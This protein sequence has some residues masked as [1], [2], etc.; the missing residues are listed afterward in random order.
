MSDPNQITPVV[1]ISGF[2][3]SGKTTLLTKWIEYYK[4]MNQQVAVIMNE[5]GDV[6]L[7]GLMINESI[8]M[9][10]MLSGCICC[11]IRGDL[12]TT[13]MNLVEQE[14]PNVILIESTGAANPLELIDGV[15]E[16]SLY[17]RIHLQ[18][19]V[20]IVDGPHLLELAEKGIGKTYK[21]MKEQ[22][23]CADVVLLNKLDR[24][25][26]TELSDLQKVVRDINTTAT[27]IETIQ[28]DVD[29]TLL[30][31][32]RLNVKRQLAHKVDHNHYPS[33]ASHTHHSH[34]HVMVYT[35]YFDGPVDSVRF[36]QFISELPHSVYRAKGVLRF[37]DTPQESRFL[38]QYAYRE[39]DYLRITPKKDTPDVLV[40]IGEH[41]PKVEIKSLLDNL[42]N[43]MECQSPDC[44]DFG[45]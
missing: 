16:A 15:T 8:P 24:V 36:E 26:S 32:D 40:L 31:P 20:I 41:I 25:D 33:Q 22:I 44:G 1:V 39:S 29:P 10:E 13:I 11:T 6:N 43:E 4:G 38:F 34:D 21:L 9:A 35:H 19:V 12:G 42:Q 30:D 7:D 28:C 14:H 5:L 37:T 18:L 23:R 3:G 27:L 17:I 45:S 2:L